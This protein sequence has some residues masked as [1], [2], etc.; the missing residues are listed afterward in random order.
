MVVA[1]ITKRSKNS[2]LQN[3]H[4]Y[5]Y[6]VIVAAR[7]EELV[8]GQLIKSIK[9]QKYPKGLIDIYGIADNCTDTSARVG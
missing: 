4:S 5:K 7:N 6:A 2:V 3:A 1:L 9:N 8:I